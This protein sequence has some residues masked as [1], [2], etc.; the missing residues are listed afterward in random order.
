M[1]PRGA[2]D[3]PEDAVVRAFIDFRR[4]VLR[5]SMRQSIKFLHG[6]NVSFG[7]IAALMTLRE[8]GG[9]SISDL[10]EEIGLSVA[11]TSQLVER[12][13]Q[14]DFV[15]RTASA[16]DRRR[17]QVALAAKGQTFLSRMEG[18]YTAA[19]KALI[20]VPAPT[21]KR[22]E[23]AFRDVLRHLDLPTTD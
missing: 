21:L 6:H 2:V 4:V 22:L 14:D 3:S 19:S 10:A 8:R 7:A 1:T 5:D 20:A 12:L 18:S 23:M 16:D 11:A 13:V 9:Q 15:K 17:K